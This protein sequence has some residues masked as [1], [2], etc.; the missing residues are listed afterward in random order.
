MDHNDRLELAKEALAS[1]YDK[2][3]IE[4]LFPELKESEDEKIRKEIIDFIYDKT[5]TYELREKSNSWLAWLE[6]QGEQKPVEDNEC[7][8]RGKEL[9]LSLQIQAYLNTASDELYAKGKPLYS[10]KRIE[11]VHKCMNM[12]AK[13]HNSYFYGEKPVEWSEEDKKIIEQICEDLQCGMENRNA[14]KIVRALHYDEIILSNIS[15]LKSL[16]SQKQ[17]KPSKEQLEQL[18]RYCP[19]NIILTGLLEQLKEL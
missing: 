15:W 6:K 11:D 12:W 8:D 4:H 18:S 17:W 10:E 16:R 5:D 7:A 13:L 9:S 1:G 19:D 2:R 14:H 3:T